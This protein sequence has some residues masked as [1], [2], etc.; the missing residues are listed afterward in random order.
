MSR[1]Y[2]TTTDVLKY[3][4]KSIVVQGTNPTP[5]PRNPSPETLPVSTAPDSA[6]IADF[7]QQACQVI[8]A[9]LGTQYD[10]PL[11]K[12][13]QGGDVGYPNPVSMLAAIMAADLIFEQRLL[14]A[15][16]QRSESEKQRSEWV[17]EQ[18][19]AIQNGELRLF[20]QRSTR[21]SRFVRNTLNTV[22]HNPASG[23][24][25]GKK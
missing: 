10:V 6:S 2:C 14:G 22:P 19:A 1:A 13:N 15:D 5:N 11:K 3:L 16:R 20:G 9:S 17:Q 4:P 8:D 18:I 23:G 24:K 21:G 25:S 7:I 12:V